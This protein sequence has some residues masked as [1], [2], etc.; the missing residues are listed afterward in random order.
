[1]TKILIF[2]LGDVLV[3]GFSRVAAVLTQRLNRAVAEVMPALGGEPLVSLTEG[4]LADATY[5]QQVLDQARWPMAVEA[6]EVLVRAIFSR[7]VR[8]MPELLTA[9]R[10]QRLMLL[11][12]QGREWMVYLDATHP[13]RGLFE[14]RFLS[15]EMGQMKRQI[16]MF[17]RVIAELGCAPQDCVFIDD[18]PWNVARAHMVGIRATPF[19][20][21]DALKGFL[22]QEHLYTLTAKPCSHE[23]GASALKRAA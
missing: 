16:T 7:P 2:D 18:L 21:V 22:A 10:A 8:G 17:Q 13:F 19:T 15:C 5:W 6:L 12:D 23:H 20:S 9:L 11:S 3:E 4:R 14:R 1:M